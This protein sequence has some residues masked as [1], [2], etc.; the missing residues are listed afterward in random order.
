M[1]RLVIRA[2]AEAD[3]EEAARWYNAQRPGLGAEFIEAVGACLERIERHPELYGEQYRHVR[4]APL[5]RFPYAVFYLLQADRI[6]VLA[7]FHIRRD[8]QRWQVRL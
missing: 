2:A 7:C 5:R 8:P 1:R 6:E 3:I 4:R